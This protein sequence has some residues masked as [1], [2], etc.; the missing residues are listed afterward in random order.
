MLFL[1]AL[2]AREKL[3]LKLELGFGAWYWG[4]GGALA[5]EQKSP[6]SA[7]RKTRNKKLDQLLQS[8]A[9]LKP[10]V[11]CRWLVLPLVGNCWFVEVLWRV[12]CED[13]QWVFCVLVFKNKNKTQKQKEIYDKKLDSITGPSTRD[14]FSMGTITIGLSVSLCWNLRRICNLSNIKVF[15]K[16]LNCRYWYLLKPT[17]KWV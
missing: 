6:L 8:C 13:L 10:L 2:G 1:E 3:Q 15:L 17:Y 7:S 16:G 5:A 9:H 4:D 12:K 14:A 11:R